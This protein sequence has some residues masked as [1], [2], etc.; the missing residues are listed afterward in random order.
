V[1]KESKTVSNPEFNAAAA[2]VMEGCRVMAGFSDEP[3]QTTRLYLTPAVAQAHSYLR[4]RMEQLDMRVWVDAVGN[5]HGL[6]AAET[7]DAP[8]LLIA[9]HI[10]TVPNSGGYDGVLGVM[11][12][13]SMVEMLGGKKLPFA[14]EVIAFPEEEGV[15]F[16]LPFLGSRALVGTLQPELLQR[17]D[18]KGVTVADA[19]RN[20]GLN[21]DEIPA[22]KFSGEVLGYF[23]IH[24][25]QGPVLE[26][27]DMRLGVVEAIVGQTRL[28]VKF[29]GKANHAGTTP[30]NLRQDAL[31][32]AAEWIT[33]V[34]QSARR[35]ASMVATVGRIETYP[36]VGNVV[37]SDVTCSLDIRHAEDA[38]RQQ[39]VFALM[40]SAEILATR[41]GLQF[42]AR[43]LLDQPAV[44]MNP[45]LTATLADAATAANVPLH[46]MT[47][48][49]GHDAM[50]VAPYMP[51]A[52]LFLRSPGGVSH[53]PEETVLAEDVT[54]ALQV[55]MQFLQQLQS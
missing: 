25:E 50:I 17:R 23:E 29:R 31:T 24:I 30:M 27:L 13:I 20:F 14:I 49:A 55:A 6:Y 40:R 10:D 8:R 48:G 35:D 26:S 38:V 54:A 34:E 47:S 37:S 39:T 42:A 4:Q 2:G 5:L 15:R 43:T 28:E 53:H 12:G 19:I 11:M 21:P 32:G 22:A 7:T 41:R 46:H 52:M 36:N 51:T 44:P 9:S 18:A 45:T 3:G 16:S 33:T 1:S